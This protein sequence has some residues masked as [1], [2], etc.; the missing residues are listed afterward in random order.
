[1]MTIPVP[2][3]MKEASLCK[4]FGSTLIEP[5]LKWL[6]SFPNGC[7]TSFAHLDNMFN[8]QFASS[9][10]L[11]KRKSDLYYVWSNDPTNP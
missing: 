3:H 8:Q 1:M 5:A 11:G 7:I 4:G 6:S 2:E 10:G 9:R